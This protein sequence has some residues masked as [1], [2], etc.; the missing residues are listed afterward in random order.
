MV[1]PHKLLER[2]NAKQF[3]WATKLF[4]GLRNSGV[5]IDHIS[6]DWRIWEM[7]LPL[8]LRTLNY[9]GTHWG[10]TLYSALDSQ[11]MLAWLHLLPDHIVWDKAAGIRFKKPGRGTLRCRIEIPAADIDAVRAACRAAPDGKHE[12]TYTLRWTDKDG[13]VVAEVDKLVY[14]CSKEAASP[15]DRA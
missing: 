15:R 6:D 9:V 5:K 8:R 12:R 3:R 13:D 1:K 7:R 4:P 14:F 2:L 11:V 10:G